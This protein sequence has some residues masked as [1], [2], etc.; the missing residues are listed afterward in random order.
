MS[1]TRW[2]QHNMFSYEVWGGWLQWRNSDWKILWMECVRKEE[3]VRYATMMKAI[4]IQKTKK[5]W[6]G[7]LPERYEGSDNEDPS[8]WISLGGVSLC[9]Q[10][11][12]GRCH[13]EEPSRKV[14]F[15]LIWCFDFLS[16]IWMSSCRATR[17]RLVRTSTTNI[18]AMDGNSCK[19]RGE[20]RGS[21]MKKVP[22][23]CQEGHFPWKKEWHDGIRRKVIDGCC[24]TRKKLD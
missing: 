17:T 3:I 7:N 12:E 8:Q 2:N 24:P 20:K 15:D 10:D 6:L 23:V 16:N 22:D 18:H 14:W 21:H 9:M 4:N 5:T 19:K 13:D 11:A 1:H